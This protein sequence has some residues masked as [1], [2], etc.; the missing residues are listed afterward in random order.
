[1]KNNQLTILCIILIFFSC[2]GSRSTAWKI[3]EPKPPT[4]NSLKS[5]IA[6]STKDIWCVGDNGT[7]LYYD[8]MEWNSFE[9][10]D[11]T[12]YCV[13]GTSS[14]NIWVVGL[15]NTV[16]HYNGYKWIDVSPQQNSNSIN[17][18]LTIYTS[19]YN[20]MIGGYRTTRKNESYTEKIAKKNFLRLRF[21]DT[22]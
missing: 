8:G 5:I 7:I 17:N 16:L 13:N 14:S 4:K 12:L 18:F 10:T 1:M 20:V 9:I 2:G 3:F 15:G 6:F 19:S 22:A 21:S 11:Q